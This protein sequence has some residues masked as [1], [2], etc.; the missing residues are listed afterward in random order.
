[1]SAGK[2]L[3]NPARGSLIP[4][5]PWQGFPL[6]PHRP[7]RPPTDWTPRWKEWDWDGW[8]WPDFPGPKGP[9]WGNI[10]PWLLPPGT[11]VP[12]EKP[13]LKKYP[14]QKGIPTTGPPKTTSKK[15]EAFE[16][17]DLLNQ[18]LM[19]A[20]MAGGERGKQGN[21]GYGVGAQVP[22]GDPWRMRADW[23]TDYRTLPS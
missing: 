14:N 23:E 15:A 12:K 10:F 2:W 17:N 20:L 3:I 1:M 21:I 11:D 18:L 13:P 9:S 22:F 6:W 7:N 5:G 4:R 19:S 16:E 8:K